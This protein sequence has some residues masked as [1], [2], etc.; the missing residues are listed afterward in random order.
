MRHLVV[1][2]LWSILALLPVGGCTRSD[3][4]S[5]LT[6]TGSSTVAPLA[7][8]IAK[9]FEARNPGVRVDVQS[10]GSGRGL[11]DARKG[12]AQIGMVSRA[13]KDDEKDLTAFTI[14]MDGVCVILHKSNQVAA[15][16]CK[17][18]CFICAD[19]KTW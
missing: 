18:H 15:L 12:L 10:G 8:E 9:R 4:A 3:A 5:K 2:I 16:K 7:L 6:L 13:L 14:A 19:G 1:S 11:S 17:Q